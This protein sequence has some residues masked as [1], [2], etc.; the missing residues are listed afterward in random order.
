[1]HGRQIAVSHLRA[2]PKRAGSNTKS[3]P[4]RPSKSSIHLWIRNINGRCCA[5]HLRPK[6][7]A[8]HF[9]LYHFTKNFPL[10][11][12]QSWRHV[13]LKPDKIPLVT[14]G[15]HGKQL[16]L[17]Y[18]MNYYKPKT[19]TTGWNYAMRRDNTLTCRTYPPPSNYISSLVLMHETGKYNIVEAIKL[20]LKP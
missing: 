19:R 16:M 14:S 2:S 5:R 9:P 7:C 20:V 12:Q 4:D 6:P 17:Q 13:Y 18:W 10:P 11:H 1:M 3:V 15:M 8:W